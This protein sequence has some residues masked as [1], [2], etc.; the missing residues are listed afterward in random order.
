MPSGDDSVAIVCSNR[1]DGRFDC[2]HWAGPAIVVVLSSLYCSIQRQI[3][4]QFVVP[5]YVTGAIAVLQLHTGCGSVTA[6]L[7]VVVAI[8]LVFGKAEIRL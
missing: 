2:F 4:S 6:A 3:S 5:T 7:R 1:R 8:V